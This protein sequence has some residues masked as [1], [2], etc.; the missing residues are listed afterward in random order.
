MSLEPYE[1]IHAARAAE[2]ERHA[3][4][5][6]VVDDVRRARRLARTARRLDTLAC[7]SDRLARRLSARAQSRRARLS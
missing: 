5:A 6:A 3:R 4:E 7:W 1:L 2:L